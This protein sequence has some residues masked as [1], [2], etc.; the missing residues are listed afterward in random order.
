MNNN[1][2]TEVEKRLYLI[3]SYDKKTLGMYTDE[4][5]TLTILYKELNKTNYNNITLTDLIPSIC[6]ICVTSILITVLISL[7]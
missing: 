6:F 2:K 5:K 7:L 4:L 3:L 1:L